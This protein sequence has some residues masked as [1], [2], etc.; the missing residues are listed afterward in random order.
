DLG[1]QNAAATVRLLGRHR[2]RNPRRCAGEP[3][4]WHYAAGVGVG[5]RAV[6]ALCTGIGT[7]ALPVARLLSWRADQRTVRHPRVANAVARLHAVGLARRVDLGDTALFNWLQC[8]AI[9]AAVVGALVD[10]A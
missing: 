6:S 10:R 4:V 8:A 5:W 9:G 2:R 1:Q 3:L 7:A